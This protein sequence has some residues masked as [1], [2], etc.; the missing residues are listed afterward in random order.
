MLNLEKTAWGWRQTYGEGKFSHFFPFPLSF[1]LLLQIIDQN[2]L[3]GSEPHMQSPLRIDFDKPF[4]TL[5][6]DLLFVDSDYLSRTIY[7]YPPFPLSLS[8]FFGVE[9]K[10]KEGKEE[11]SGRRDPE[12]KLFPSPEW[13]ENKGERENRL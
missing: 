11:T 1:D 6:A 9:L 5:K 3:V 2:R 10:E 12:A 7:V 8:P 13:M 4:L